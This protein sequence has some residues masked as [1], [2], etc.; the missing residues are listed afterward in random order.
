M[1]IANMVEEVQGADTPEPME[2]IA[3][4]GN[5]ME[6]KFITKAVTGRS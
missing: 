6:E 4:T 2:T 5:K 3:E 1:D